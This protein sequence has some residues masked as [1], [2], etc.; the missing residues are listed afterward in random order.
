MSSVELEITAL[1]TEFPIPLL[2]N[3]ISKQPDFLKNLKTASPNGINLLLKTNEIK[4]D[5][6]CVQVEVGVR[7]DRIV[8]ITSPTK[9]RFSVYSDHEDEVS[10]KT[11]DGLVSSK[12]TAIELNIKLTKQHR[13]IV[14]IVTNQSKSYIVIA[15]I[16]NTKP[17][18]IVQDRIYTNHLIDLNLVRLKRL[19]IFTKKSF[20]EESAAEWQ[21]DSLVWHVQRGTNYSVT[22]PAVVLGALKKYLVTK[23]IV[24][25]DQIQSLER[26]LLRWLCEFCAEYQLKITSFTPYLVNDL[27]QAKQMQKVLEK[28]NI[29]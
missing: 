6:C 11:K 14:A 1:L 4:M 17:I 2:R 22:N 9:Q 5:E 12:P 19:Y 8:Y 27:S 20:R 15:P 16:V 28:M 26:Q 21:I 13:V 7:Q 3:T 23:A 18:E 24:N 29:F 10:I 25:I